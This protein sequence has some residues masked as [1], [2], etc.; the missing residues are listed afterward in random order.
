MT[1]KCLSEAYKYL[2]EIS[3]IN[4]DVTNENVKDPDYV[5]ETRK[6]YIIEKAIEKFN[7]CYASKYYS[8][9]YIS[10]TSECTARQILTDLWEECDERTM[11]E[12]GI[13]L[14]LIEIDE[15]KAFLDYLI[16]KGVADE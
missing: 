13:E 5:K 9:R 3:D 14:L 7:I 15:L 4:S 10:M 1:E 11:Y 6:I 12:N 2:K 16:A 8:D